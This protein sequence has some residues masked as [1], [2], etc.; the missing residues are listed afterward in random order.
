MEPVAAPGRWEGI[1][2]KAMNQKQERRKPPQPNKIDEASAESFPASDPPSYM[3]STAVAGAP[4]KHRTD[5]NESEPVVEQE[6]RKVDLNTAN[7]DE[8]GS[9]P[10]L[11]PALTKTL[12][13]NRPFEA[14][15]E[16]ERLPGFDHAKVEELKKGGAEI[17]R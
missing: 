2:D 6:R 4:N 16:V 15:H 3:G 11:S 17:R 13:A 1:W 9:L 5:R 8:I 12:V 7:S 14:W 10:A